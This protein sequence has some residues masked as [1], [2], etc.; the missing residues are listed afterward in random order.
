[1]LKFHLGEI[2]RDENLARAESGPTAKHIETITF[3]RI[4]K[5]I[6]WGF[7]FATDATLRTRVVVV[8][9]G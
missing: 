3:M 1:M 2:S 5:S 8:E 4:A 7:G 6:Y 9:T